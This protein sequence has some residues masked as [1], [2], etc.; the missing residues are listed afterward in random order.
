MKKVS[1]IIIGLLIVSLFLVSCASEEVSEEELNEEL[2]GLSDQDFV[3]VVTDDD[4]ALA[5]QATRRVSTT[6]SRVKKKIERVKVSWTCEQDNQLV[7]MISS[8]GYRRVLNVKHCVDDK[9]YKF[10]CDENDLG[11]KTPVQVCEDGCEDNNCVVEEEPVVIKEELVMCNVDCTTKPLSECTELGGAEVAVD[12]YALW[13]SRGCCKIESD[14]FCSFGL[15][16]F[17]CKQKVKNVL[18][19]V[20]EEDYIFDHLNMNELSCNSQYCNP[21]EEPEEESTD[22]EEETSPSSVGAGSSGS[23]GAVSTLCD[24]IKVEL[25]GEE[26]LADN[27][28]LV[29]SGDLNTL[30]APGKFENNKGTYFYRQNLEFDNNSK[31]VTNIED[32]NDELDN[33]FFVEN[34]DNIVTYNLI[35][36]TAVQSDIMNSVYDDL[37]NKTLTLFAEDYTITNALKLEFDNSIE[38]TLSGDKKIVLRDNDFTDKTNSGTMFI[39]DEQIDGNNV[40][41][42]GSIGG[43]AFNLDSIQVDIIAEDNFYVGVEETLR[44]GIIDQGEETDALISDNWNIRFN[45]YNSETGISVIEIGKLCDL[46]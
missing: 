38:L 18:G 27:N 12:E 13:C 29:D 3:E 11:W 4:S 43:G 7:T 1:L 16:K 41:I 9:L 8:L 35:F 30:F 2:E 46:E 28:P 40:Q 45:S 24:S 17:E 14:D 6:A 19:N 37:L 10:F 36:D 25:A 39:D 5:G 22:D 34:G 32:D 33:H 42:E 20:R 44:E 26:T 31:L 23:G 15:K 21:V